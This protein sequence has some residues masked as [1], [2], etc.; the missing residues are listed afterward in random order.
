MDIAESE[1]ADTM[2]QGSRAGGVWRMSEVRGLGCANLREAVQSGGALHGEAG[3]Q[4]EG[5]YQVG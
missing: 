5:R 2:K 3:G 4:R 1:E